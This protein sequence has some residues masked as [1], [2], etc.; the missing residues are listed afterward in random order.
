[1]IRPFSG[2]DTVTYHNN[3]S[4]GRKGCYRIQWDEFGHSS[5][6]LFSYLILFASAESRYFK[7]KIS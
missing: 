2:F 7:P 5:S 3:L 4:Q 6:P 1:M